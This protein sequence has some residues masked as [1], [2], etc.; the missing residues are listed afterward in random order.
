MNDELKTA[1]FSS[2]LIV[3]RSLRWR[4]LESNQPLRLF[5]PALA[6]VSY[7]SEVVNRK[8]DLCVKEVGRPSTPPPPSSELAPPL[9]RH[10]LDVQVLAPRGVRLRVVAEQQ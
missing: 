8:P 10:A 4:Q 2:S 5:R 1:C 6:R 7:A 3:H 9:Q